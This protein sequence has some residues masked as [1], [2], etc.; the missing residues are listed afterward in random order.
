MAAQMFAK[1]LNRPVAAVSSG[2]ALAVELG[3]ENV[4]VCGD[5]RRGMFWFG[6][7]E[8]GAMSAWKLCTAEIFASQ[9]KPG[10]VI[11]TPHWNQTAALRAADDGARGW[12][13]GD[14]HP[15][16]RG[17]ARLALNRVAVGP[18]EPIYLHPPV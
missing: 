13:E 8:H 15:T 12:L 4:V 3:G 1:P 7:R 14:R 11:V 5:A 17:I 9:T 10:A 2:E 16:A 6:V 18:L